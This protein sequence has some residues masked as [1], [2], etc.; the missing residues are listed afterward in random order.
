MNFERLLMIMSLSPTIKFSSEMLSF[1]GRSFLEIFV[2][3]GKNVRSLEPS[4]ANIWLKRGQIELIE[5]FRN[6]WLYSDR[7]QQ[8]MFYTPI[9]NNLSCTKW[10]MPVRTLQSTISKNLWQFT[11]FF[12]TEVK[13]RLLWFEGCIHIFM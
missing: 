12:F 2:V 1:G 8:S 6:F 13:K 4:T 3:E 11:T 7:T 5:R 9:V 10:T